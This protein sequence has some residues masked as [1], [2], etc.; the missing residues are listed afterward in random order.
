M[1]EELHI[2]NFALIDQCVVNFSK[3]L[4]I[5]TG[6]TGAGKSVLIGALGL[7]LGAK[8][9]S[10][11]IRTGE[12]EA[13]VTGV[14]EIKTD[15]VRSWLEEHDL[16]SRED[17]LIIRRTL[18]STGRG[19]ISIQARPFPLNE[20]VELGKL[21]VDV[22]GQHDHQTLFHVDYHRRYLDSY[23][24]L[25]EAVGKITKLFY[26]VK[27]LS[28][29][30][31]SL[32]EVLKDK[33]EE[34]ELLTYSLEEI[35]KTDIRE[36]EEDEIRSRLKFMNQSQ[37]LYSLMDSF[38]NI[39]PENHGGALRTLRQSL[40]ILE[41][42]KGLNPDFLGVE[43]R[44]SNAFYELE[45]IVQTVQS[46]QESMVFDPSEKE[47]LEDRLAEIKKIY[48]KYAPTYESLQEYCQTSR[49]RLE[50]LAGGESNLGD[51]EKRKAWLEEE[52]VEKAQQLSAERK[53][54]AELLE[55]DVRE[56]LRE[57]GMTSADFSIRITG[58]KSES[59]QNLCG[60]T[61]IDRVE[62]LFSANRGEP[63]KPLRQ[64]ASGGEISRV[65]LAIKTALADSGTIPVLV[66]DEIDAG[67]GGE[68]AKSIGI[69]MKKLSQFNQILCITHLASIAVYADNHIKV[70]KFD[71]M[72]RTNT[73]LY[74]LDGSQKVLEIAR[75]LSGDSQGDASLKHAKALL[76]SASGIR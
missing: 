66:F 50:E 56:M 7:I 36:G 5:L 53:K 37:Q 1:I 48:R 39:M 71:A 44:F 9:D 68:V 52:L 76:E 73:S 45:D 75:M 32:K 16:D 60:V 55:K 69:H 23:G 47:A 49:T 10:S 40:E 70:E 22:H 51:L 57:L 27:E 14:F 65:M 30:I 25:E 33:D 72:D 61:G 54:Q 26:S 11:A 35:G 3:G 28:E 19:K 17:R 59:G 12:E 42:L 63:V 64:V 46:I 15:E 18:K 21:L 62:F 29:E 74:N 20:L 34:I 8:G 24:S 43:E 6:E 58:R 31:A 41:D 38:M 2:R 67:I 13:D 4:N